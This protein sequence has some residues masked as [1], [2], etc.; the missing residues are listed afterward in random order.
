MEIW[1]DI[2]EFKGYYQVSNL[3]R[4]RSLDRCIK[5]SD[6][7]VRE[8]KGKIINSHKNKNGYV[9]T[10]LKKDGKVFTR[11]NHRLVA[12]AF[13][14]NEYNYPCINHKDEI[15]SNN[16]VENLEWCTYKYNNNYGSCKEKRKINTDYKN[17]KLG[18]RNIKSIYQYDIEGNL[19]K[20]YESAKEIFD[21]LGYSKDGIRKCCNNDIKTYKSF[22]WQYNEISKEE[23]KSRIIR[24]THNNGWKLSEETKNK[25]SIS[26][27]GKKRDNQ[28]K[29]KMSKS[30]KKMTGEKNPKSKKVLCIELNEIF[31]GTREA[32]RIL[33]ICSSSISNCCNGKRKTAGGYQWKYIGGE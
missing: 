6:G 31:N 20:K 19:I 17:R 16:V 22:V 23:I 25:I 24:K 21:T 2:E 10:G 27:T 12:T 33:N 15:R 8:Y 32:A 9:A 26:N 1:K 5:Y 29:I 28:F 7:T 18:N 4:I 14:K 11:Y 3:G 30:R 13:I